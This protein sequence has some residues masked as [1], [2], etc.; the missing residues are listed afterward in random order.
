MK[1]YNKKLFKRPCNPLKCNVVINND[2]ELS[3]NVMKQEKKAR[4]YIFI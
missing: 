3:W 1:I 4:K 2:S